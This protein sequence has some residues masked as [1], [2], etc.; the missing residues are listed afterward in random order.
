MA[1][2]R[3]H[4]PAFEP[5]PSPQPLPLTK[6]DVRRNRIMEKLQG[7]ID[8]FAANQNGHYRAQL[9]G[10]QVDMTLVLRADPYGAEGPLGDSSDEIRELVESII[11]PDA[12]GNG[13]VN[14][15]E[16]ESAR[17]DFWALAGKRYGEF[18]TEVNDAIERR[19]ADLTALH[20]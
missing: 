6:R 1:I 9:Q 13:G 17:T 18:V 10:V 11:S 14:L 5:S 4:S 19:D 8:T 20:V 7:M 16:Q 2:A 3:H 12:Q 15:P